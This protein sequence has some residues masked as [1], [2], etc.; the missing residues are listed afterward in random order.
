L[1]DQQNADGAASGDANQSFREVLAA[2]LSRRE[3]RE[4]QTR[5]TLAALLDGLLGEVE[6]A[7]FLIALRMKGETADEIAAGAQ[8]L[9]DRMIRWDTGLPAV[10]DTCGT[11]GDGAGTFNIS[12]ATA[13][14]VAAAGVPVVKHG[15]RAVSSRSGSI[16]VLAC[17]GVTPAA[18][19][20]TARCRL[21]QC[22][23]AFCSA[24]SFHPAL[25][26][27]GPLR[28]R[29]GVSTLFNW[30]GPLANPAGA[31]HQLLGVGRPE[32]LDPIAGALAKLGTRR[33]L[34]VSSRDGLDEI[35]LSASTLVR[36]VRGS[37]IIPWEWTAADFGLE[38]CKI[39]DLRADGPEASAAMI[40]SV[41]QGQG[42]AASRVVLA[43][44][45]AALLAAEKAGTLQEGVALASAAV[46]GGQALRV[47]E[48]LAKSVTVKD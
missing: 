22:G 11:G 39:D 15:N 30:L 24:P 13:F 43:N 44:A 47:L 21:Q 34:V 10:L 4:S 46:A 25:K 36:E 40:R 41:L 48:S 8:V 23:L 12:T 27:L 16:D 20:D 18:D 9:R 28:R 19:P 31:A 6:A 42:G 7:T 38:P 33:A 32:L 1:P 29:L 5:N 2:L 37:Q 45:A 17:L 3:L 14:V 26:Q 35:S